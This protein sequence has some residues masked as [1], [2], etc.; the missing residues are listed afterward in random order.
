LNGGS[1]QDSP[2]RFDIDSVGSIKAF[3]DNFDGKLVG[4]AEAKETLAAYTMKRVVGDRTVEVKIKRSDP[5]K[6]DNLALSKGPSDNYPRTTVNGTL[7]YDYETGNYFADGI[8]FS[9]SADGKDVTDIVTGSIKWVEDA[10]RKS[11]GKGHYEFNLRWNEDAQK[12]GGDEAAAFGKMSE[13]EAFFAV[14]NSLPSL[15]GTVDYVDSMSGGVVTSSK[16]TYHLDANRLTKQQTMA[17]LKLWL[18]SI[19]PTND[20]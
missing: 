5:M 12:K 1:A 19:A 3:K 10:D 14:D 16:V 4:K 6:F 7:N 8:R 2:L 18:I 11:N 9:Y 15:T 17:F 13:E 20:E